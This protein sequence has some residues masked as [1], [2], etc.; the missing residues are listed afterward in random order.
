MNLFLRMLTSYI[1][2]P[3]FVSQ[4]MLQESAIYMLILTP[5]VNF[6]YPILFL[7]Y[8]LGKFKATWVQL[9]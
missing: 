9:Q 4:E 1:K 7:F 3:T 5:F 2:H 8:S 6:F